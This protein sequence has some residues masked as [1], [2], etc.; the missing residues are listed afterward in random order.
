MTDE[1]NKK[2][3]KYKSKYL[4]TK[5]AISVGGGPNAQFSQWTDENRKSIDVRT[6]IRVGE[7]IRY[8]NNINNAEH[9]GKV[10]K[11]IKNT[12]GTN[13]LDGILINLY[14][15]AQNIILYTRNKIKLENFVTKET[16]P[17]VP[18]VG[19][20]VADAGFKTGDC[21]KTGAKHKISGEDI[22]YRIDEITDNS[23]C[24]SMFIPSLGLYDNYHQ[25]TKYDSDVF[26]KTE[27]PMKKKDLEDIR[28]MHEQ[29]NIDSRSL[30]IVGPSEFQPTK[31]KLR[32]EKIMRDTD[33]QEHHTLNKAKTILPPLK[34]VKLLNLKK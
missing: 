4:K 6:N 17:T 27:C 10:Y 31:T 20:H 5:N 22:I 32:I 16:D 14:D 30:E 13:T 34:E 15:S 1:Y 9:L 24:L 8:K 19:K 11:F 18:N 3:L 12:D 28:K 29:I 7:F 2:Y 23:V 26:I 33:Q 21:M 25:L